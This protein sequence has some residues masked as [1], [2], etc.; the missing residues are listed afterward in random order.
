M[1]IFIAADHRGFN[2]KNQ[3]IDYLQEKN[4]RVEDLGAYEYQA[5]DDYPDVAKKVAQA[6]LQNPDNHLGIVICGSGVGV[7]ISTNRFKGIRCG[8]GFDERQVIH[9]RENDHINVLALASDFL[10]FE[11]AKILVDRFLTTAGKS[12]EKYLR[13]IRKLEE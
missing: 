7:A 13:R 8:L 6:V 3:I 2:L 11:T 4:I 12:E 9:A 1:T 5:D 10:D